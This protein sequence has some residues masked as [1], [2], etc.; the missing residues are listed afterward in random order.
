MT[1][2]ASGWYAQQML[3]KCPVCEADNSADAAECRDCGKL[4]SS[5]AADLPE[6]VPPIDGLEQTIHDPR[7]SATGPVATLP[8]LERTQLA[9][10]DLKVA[11]EMVRDVE[12][13]Q[14]EVDP[15]AVSLWSSAGV[16]MDLGREP[17]DG[18]RTPAPQD[19]G[20]CP[21]C[22]EPATGVVCDNCGRRRSRYSV[23]VAAAEQE[24]VEGETVLCPA[25][26]G[27]VPT[28]ARCTEC[29]VPFAVVE[30]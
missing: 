5:R 2:P 11:A 1:M 9:R 30:L 13:T 14:I 8:E 18:E 23:P 17:D 27:R 10:K 25:C 15:N 12:Q 16:E 3:V 29:G 21:W 22:N 28:G 24:A 7:E 6:D 26:F 19:T 4:L 20:V